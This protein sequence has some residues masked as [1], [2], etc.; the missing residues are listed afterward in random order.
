MKTVSL[1]KTETF[2]LWFIG[3]GLLVF[4]IETLLLGLWTIPIIGYR[5]PYMNEVTT[6]DLLFAGS[7]AVAFGF[8]VSLF[9][10]ARKGKAASCAVGGG[11]GLLAFFT[12]LCPVC[13]VF[14][15]TYFGLSATV[16][17][18]SPY[19][20]WMRVI[21][22]VVLIAGIALLARRFEPKDVPT[23]SGHLIFQKVAVIVVGILFVSNQAL[24]MQVGKKMIG[25]DMADGVVLTGEFARDI[26]ALVTPTTLPFYGSELGLDMSNLNAIN[27]SIRKLGIMAPMQGSNPIQ[28]SEEE[29]KRYIKIGTEPYVTCEFCCGVTT[30]VRED[31]SPT[32]GCA[33]SIAMRGTAAYLIRT[34]PEM[35]D[36]QIAYEIVRQKGLY[37]PV[38][39][40]QR[41]ASSLAGDR[42]EFKP[43]IKYL[44]MNLTESEL[45]DLQKKAKTSGFEP[46]ENPG[47]VGGC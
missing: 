47:M 37:F 13:P 21:A 31:G 40:Q 7:F 3:G 41:M 27:A 36:A 1:L 34:Y 24:A 30:L 33:H 45:T 4:A 42:A 20:W 17:A 11:S 29:M 23:K 10:L 38:Q 44:T 35:T 18:F 28:L 15:L 25:M 5:I 2:W 43:D 12:M 8:G 16:M 9:A 39:L 14:F 46:E 32:C 19:F 22:F 26:A 6:F